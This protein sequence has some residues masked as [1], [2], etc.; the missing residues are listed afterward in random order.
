MMRMMLR[1]M[2]T[3]ER[4]EVAEQVPRDREVRDQAARFVPDPL[5]R[6]LDRA[7]RVPPHHHGQL[8]IHSGELGKRRLASVLNLPGSDLQTSQPP[9]CAGH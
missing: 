7:E 5:R 2:L 1:M 4:D 8:G 9:Q 6:V 3:A